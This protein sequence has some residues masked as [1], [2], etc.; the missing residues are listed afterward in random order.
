[1]KRIFWFLAV[2]V[3]GAIPVFAQLT[4][5]TLSG[6]VSG[7]DGL[8][9]GASVVVKD[10]QTG[11]EVTVVTNSEGG[12]KVPNLQVGTY[13]VTVTA[14]GFKTVTANNVKIE[15]N[16]DF[17]LPVTLELGNVSEVVE[18]TS[19]A[20]IVNSVDAKIN[21]TVSRKQLEDLPSL[22]RNPLNFVTLQAGAASNPN[23]NTV[24]NGI[25]TSATNITIDGI[26]VQDNFIRSNATDF[27]PARPS[28][29]E[30]E[31]FAVSTQN[32]ADDGFGG[33]QIQF[34]TRRGGNDYHVRLFEFNRN[35]KLSANNFFNNANGTVR[36][37]RNR[38]QFGGNFSGP[39]PF[40]NFGEG[41]PI[42]NNGK[43]KLFFF[44]AYERLI[45]RQP[46]DPQFSTV[47]TNNARQGLFTYTA[48]AND[49]ANN[50]V[51]GQTVS[52]NILNPTF[53]TGITAI[54]PIIASRFLANIPQGNTTIVGDQRN[55]TGRVVQQVFNP[56]QTN[57]TARIDFLI[58]SKNQLTGT[59]RGVTQ[60]LL[61]ADIDNT[62]NQK[63][64]VRQ[65]SSNPFVSIGLTSTITSNL[66]NEV[67]GGVF[68]SDPSFLRT[69]TYPSN[70]ITLPLVTNP[71]LFEVGG[72]FLNQGR[73]V[74]TFNFQ[75]NATYL[76][77]NH[78]I[79][80]GGQV[81]RV[82]INAFNDRGIVPNY[83]LGINLNTPQIS[84]TQF[85]NTALF[86]GQVPT[87][88]RAA[89][90][91]LLALLGGIVSSGSQAFNVD[92][93]TS[94]FI[95]GATQR[96]LYSYT[97]Y[98]ASVADQWRVTPELTV[99]F[100][101]RY[102]LYTGLKLT[103]GL[104]LEP[105]IADANNPL[106]SLLNPAGTY[107]FIGGNIGKPNQFYNSD[108]N[109]FSPV[110]SFAYAPGFSSGIGKMFFGEKKT[111][112]RGGYRT[113][114]INDELVRAPDNALAGNA[115]LNFTQSAFNP[116]DN[117]TSLNARIGSLPTIT[118][119]VFSGPNR[120]FVQ[121]NL[122]AG[123]FGTVFAIN[124][125]IKSPRVQEY[126]FGIQREIGFGTAVEIRYVGTRS[127]NLLRGVDYNQFDITSNG[128]LA[129]FNRARANYVLT[130]NAACTTA[131]CQTLTVFPNLG[132][133][134]GSPGGLTNSTVISNLV[135]GT[136]ADLAFV[137]VTNNLAG[138]VKFLPNANTGAVDYL[139][140][141]AKFNYNALQIDVRRR[142]GQGLS[143]AAN[144]TFSKNLSNAV[145][146]G[147]TRF[148]PLIDN[149]QP[150]LEYSRADFDQ[151]HKFN[152]LSTYELPFG[153]GRP[154]LNEGIAAT[155]LGNF[156]IGA[157]LQIGSGSPITITDALNSAGQLVRGTLNRAG[158]SGRQTAVTSLTKAE[159]KSLAGIYR[160]PNGIFIL[161]PEVLGRNADGT[162]NT[163]IGGSGRGA[164]GFGTTAFTGQ[165]FFNNAPGQSSGLERAIFNGPTRYN[166]DL[167]LIKRFVITEKIK[168]QLQG[169]LFN[170]LNTTNFLSGSQFLDINST[171]FGRLD[172]TF[173]ARVVQL[174]LR[175]EF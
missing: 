166:L 123:R 17:A 97:A 76:I 146:T 94:G 162:I 67:R 48:L 49:P 127:N 114:Y 159:L 45:D 58:N 119:P 168:V 171:N 53:G 143:L 71:E 29:D 153:K 104:A 156:Q 78:S 40:L 37:F 133:L 145:G 13:T 109:N 46:A 170:A 103:N 2:I 130:G 131:G 65:P 32:G 19:G 95:T 147:Q 160:T 86:P 70:F 137:Y 51:A 154:F 122:A 77:G 66:T 16:K 96:R 84:T 72:P 47:L 64:V 161:P 172:S 132:V 107:Q 169:D 26:N 100:G 20:E 54:N 11:K 148:E 90:N 25:R 80:F 4:S 83:A 44:F 157:I 174:A 129:D 7:P 112:I 34:S 102:D 124:P 38:N 21:N 27:S 60:D 39:L 52:V 167:S 55:T 150:G 31:E 24:I 125:N 69:D 57:Y 33:A 128:F 74:K 116:L 8:I 140:N 63:P 136:P 89:A 152:L 135:A 144:Y 35:S 118:T 42:F 50:V 134:N 61:R 164:N 110:V 111:V 120:T 15:V 139:T 141:G 98:G 73:A 113:S 108:K 81:Q 10:S 59:Y 1:M 28:V 30:V 6:T 155:L 158:R 85:M 105:V 93:Q 87:A 18:V 3:I 149:A 138:T 101:L 151:T 79:R 115:G 142:F 75:D 23:Q 121:N 173:S 14:S 82:K 22:G 91:S 106:P 36:P 12:F 43:D 126:S 56:I 163:A 92:T 175:L 5:S 62:F 99:N 68:K 88:Q 165:K 117:S 9:P 41:V